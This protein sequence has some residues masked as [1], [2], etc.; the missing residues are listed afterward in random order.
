VKSVFILA[1]LWLMAGGWSPLRAGDFRV[2]WLSG[3]SIKALRFQAGAGP[4]RLCSVDKPIRCVVA[5]SANSA[6]CTR[7]AGGFRCTSAGA[8][9]Q[10]QHFT[11]VSESPFILTAAFTKTGKTGGQKSAQVR[12]AEIR[13]AAKSARIILAVDLDTY[14]TGVLRGEAGIL[15][16]PPALQA[17]AVVARTWA[18]RWRGRHRREGFDFCSL[19]HC[20]VFDPPPP[21]T[22]PAL[23]ALARAVRETGGE[24]LKFHGRLIDVYFSADCGGMTEAA[25][26][27][28]PDR[29][30]PYLTA[31]KDPYCAGSQHSSWQTALSLDAIG[32][33]LRKDMRIPVHG[34]LLNLKIESRDGSGRARTLRLEGGSSQRV[35]AN[36]FRYAVDRKLGWNTLKSNLYTVERRGNALVFTGRGL[37]HGVGLCQA[38]AERMGQLGISAEKILATYFPGTEVGEISPVAQGDPILSSEHFELVF[39]ESQQPWTAETLHSLESARRELESLAGALPAQVR[40]ETFAAT[41]DFIRVSGLPGWAAASTD[42]EKILLQ[43]LSSLERK[44]ILASTLRHELAH[45]AIHHRRSSKVPRWFEEGVVLFLT[46]EHVAAAPHFDFQGRNL[47]RCISHPRSEAEMKAAYALALSRVDRLVRERGREALWEVLENPSANDLEWLT[48]QK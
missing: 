3:R 38:G 33:I 25:Q 8:A 40:V 14:V 15:K 28:W 35:D 41:T 16:S 13:A 26:N 7:L 4:L 12:V 47:E 30:A 2:E 31:I 22:N 21:T 11:A 44:G 5:A 43:P 18:L 10:L 1:S 39:P 9:G 27:V 42:G 46:G 23:D 20:Q 45:L 19:T 48:D 37:G 32:G 36:E 17:M 34:D 6:D 24:V 29:A